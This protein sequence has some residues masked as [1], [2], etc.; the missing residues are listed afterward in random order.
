MKVLIIRTL[1]LGDVA[2]IGVPA[3]RRI[4]RRHPDAE[5]WF[6]TLGAGAEILELVPE[7]DRIL[8][9]DQSDWPDTIV[10]AIRSFAAIAERLAGFGFDLVYNIDT[11]FMPC[12]LGRMLAELGLEVVGNTTRASIEEIAASV[13]NATIR[14]EDVL[15]P[16]RFMQS[17]FPGMGAWNTRWWVDD[18]NA[19]PHGR[20]Y[21]ERCCGL[22]EPADLPLGGELDVEEDDSVRDGE[23]PVIALG[24]DSRTRA[25]TYA[26]QDA[27]HNLFEEAGFSVWSRFDGSQP[28]VKT[29]GQLASSD[30]CV[31]VSSAPQWLA[32]SVGCPS[33]LIPGNVPPATL[34]PEMAIAPHLDCQH[35]MSTECP[36]GIDYACMDV[37]PE[38]ILA[39]TLRFLSEVPPAERRS[40]TRK[41]SH[42]T[43][44][45]VGR[46]ITLTF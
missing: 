40:R 42:A 3:A 4:R 1:G 33:L 10:P 9:I 2:C 46:A 24:L 11:W 18:P 36:E 25:R 30:L 29:L 31:T 15:Y 8:R 20:F 32:A 13:R 44:E 5:L 22:G 17:T 35:C 26:H 12:V 41:K 39:A 43:K 23:K 6:L 38:V 27:L 14:Q 7:V 16:S 21:L 28:M 34:R 19:G 45:L 37:A